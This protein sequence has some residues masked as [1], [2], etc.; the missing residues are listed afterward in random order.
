VVTE[1]APARAPWWQSLLD[2]VFPQSPS[3]RAAFAFG[4]VAVVF[5]SAFL[6]SQTINLRGRLRT[7][8]EQRA[9]AR[10]EGDE[11]RRELSAE[12]EQAERLREEV[13]RQQ[14]V[15][16]ELGEAAAAA[17]SAGG[18]AGGQGEP[19]LVAALDLGFR[20]EDAL[21]VFT[22]RNTSVPRGAPRPALLSVPQGAKFVRVRVRARAGFAS[23]E[24]SVR[25]GEGRE[26]LTRAG[27]AARKAQT[28]QA[29]TVLVP[30]DKLNAGDYTVTLVGRGADGTTEVIRE[31]TVTVEKK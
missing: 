13:A 10:R 7:A 17:P 2:A 12:R 18:A 28:G 23:Y 16:E 6:F 14:G 29:V 27:L 3:A 1:T 22:P 4:V 25:D 26:V 9:A 21:P 11:A 8:D 24:V 30:A 20:P 31:Y 19:T 5:G 15:I